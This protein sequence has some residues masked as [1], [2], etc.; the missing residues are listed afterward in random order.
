MNSSKVNI[1][2]SALHVTYFTAQLIVVYTFEW[3]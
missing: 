3:Y 2:K 1:R